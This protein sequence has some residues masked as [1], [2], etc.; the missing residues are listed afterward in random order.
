MSRVV[1]ILLCS[2]GIS[3]QS[4]CT[5]GSRDLPAE[6]DLYRARIDVAADT[7]PR[8]SPNPHGKV[9]GAI[10]GGTVGAVGVGLGAG[11]IAA[12]PCVFLGPFAAACFS[13]VVPA[14]TT[15]AAIGGVTGVAYGAATADSTDNPEQ[16]AAKREML[17]TAL[18]GLIIQELLID[19]LQRKTRESG[20]IELPVVDPDTHDATATWR[21][22]IATIDIAPERTDSDGPYALLASADLAVK[23]A[24]SGVTVFQKRYHTLSP[25]KLTTT[26][27]GK[28]NAAAVRIALEGLMYA[29]ADQMFNKLSHEE[30][31]RGGV[32]WADSHYKKEFFS[33]MTKAI[34]TNVDGT[35]KR[36]RQPIQLPSGQ[37]L[38]EVQYLRESYLC[39]Y[40]GCID[41]EQERK[42]FE[43]RVEAGHSYMPFALQDCDK[44][45]MGI[46]DTGKSA[47][48]DYAS[49]KAIGFW[50]LGDLTRD[51]SMHIVVAGELPPVTCEG[52]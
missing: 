21:I 8:V 27:W 40:G 5:T 38:V 49:K 42:S 23:K 17:D 47:K 22:A 19:S 11:I 51:A 16:L 3:L 52:K 1:L 10:G 9:A 48:D 45:W 25:E 50:R 26:E 36:D 2:L 44:A 46:L 29:L 35:E 37:H 43:L 12:L 30:L 33:R 4:G 18:T 24:S 32:L 20:Q 13:A 6:F 7:S 28:D 34:I 41:F 31:T 14:A 15:G 39:G